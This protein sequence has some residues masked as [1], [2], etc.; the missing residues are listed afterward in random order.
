MNPRMQFFVRRHNRT[1]PR[2]S[3][4][5]SQASLFLSQTTTALL[6]NDIRSSLAG[7][8][9]EVSEQRYLYPLVSSVCYLVLFVNISVEP[10]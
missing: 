6:V 5:I 3:N 4:L 1:A 9:E 7:L 10:V 8:G 2:K